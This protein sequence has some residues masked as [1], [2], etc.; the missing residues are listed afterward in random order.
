MATMGSQ[1]AENT[2]QLLR[3]PAMAARL[4]ISYRTLKRLVARRRVPVIR[5]SAR[6][7]LFDPYD[8]VTALK[9]RGR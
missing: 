8:V 5:L 4:G 6:L 3:G 1:E 2:S 9:A 7:H